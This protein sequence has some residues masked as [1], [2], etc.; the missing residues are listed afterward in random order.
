MAKKSSSPKAAFKVVGHLRFD[1]DAYQPGETVEMSADEAA[2]LV[3]SGVLE[4]AAPE[5]PAA[6]A[7]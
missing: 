2:P 5:K 3:E 6:P 1:G 7:K 4:V